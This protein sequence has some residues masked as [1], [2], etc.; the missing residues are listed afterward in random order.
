[1]SKENILQMFTRLGGAGFF[2]KRDSW[3]HPDTVAKVISVGGLASGTL[4]GDPP[5]HQPRG[6]KPLVVQALV[7]YQGAR[8]MPQVLTGAGTFAYTQVDRPEWWTE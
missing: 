6:W 5:Y 3:S 4:P 7:S 8:P 2:V 1:M